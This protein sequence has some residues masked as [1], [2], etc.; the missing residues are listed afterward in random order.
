VQYQDTAASLPSDNCAALQAVQTDR[1]RYGIPT[2]SEDQAKLSQ[3]GLYGG[4][5]EPPVALS[6]SSAAREEIPIQRQGSAYLVPVRINRTITLPFILDTGA[7]ELVIPVDVALTLVRAGTLS[8]KDFIGQGHYR[9]ANGSEEIQDRMV[10]REVQVGDH[11]ATDVTASVS[12][13]AGSPLLGESFL[14]KFGTV[15][16]DYNRLVLILSH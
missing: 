2:P 1:D 5:W 8:R 3:C 9:M 7:E 16:I 6:P 12:S 10:I 13:I 15:T 14:S 11:T 4:H